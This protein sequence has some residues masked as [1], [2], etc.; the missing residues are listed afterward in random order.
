M[1]RGLARLTVSTTGVLMCVS[2][3][4]TGAWGP[5]CGVAAGRPDVAATQ[6]PCMGRGLARM[7]V[8]TTGVL[9]R[10]SR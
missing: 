5:G 6:Q 10:V 3:W 9:M 8:S 4:V 7:T 2:G 1:G